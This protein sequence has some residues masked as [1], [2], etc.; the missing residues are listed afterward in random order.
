MN[1]PSVVN[2]I[3]KG[4]KSVLLFSLS[5]ITFL[6]AFFTVYLPS[7][8]LVHFTSTLIFHIP[9]QFQRFQ[10]IFPILDHSYLWTQLSVSIIYSITPF[11]SLIMLITARISFLKNNIKNSF[12]TNLYLIW[13]NAIGVQFFFGALAVG[14]PLIK[15]FG[16]LPDWLYFPSW[17]NVSLIV[18]SFVVLL[19]N[20]VVI[21]HQVEFLMYNEQQQ[22]RPYYSFVFKW[23]TILAPALLLILI[24]IIA[25]FPN[26]TLYMR[27]FW[28]I[29]IMQL[30]SV[31]PFRFIYAPVIQ[32][33]EE[34]FI[35]RSF[36]LLLILMILFLISWKFTHSLLFPITRI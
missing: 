6:L 19:A 12:A 28:C 8:L 22:Q 15:D 17:I 30:I 7:Q 4:N 32:S 25:G 2:K 14:I 13:L 23:Y 29:F 11:W 10:L 1:N 35:P 27:L 18:F 20:G 31:I 36:V 34:I 33:E 5:I 21:R 9:T 26:N 24:F 3:V 16:Y